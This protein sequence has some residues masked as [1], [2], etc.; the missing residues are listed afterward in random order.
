MIKYNYHAVYINLVGQ[1]TINKAYI[2]VLK[3]NIVILHIVTLASKDDHCDDVTTQDLAKSDGENN[4]F[5]VI[6]VAKLITCRKHPFTTK[7][8]RQTE[9]LTCMVNFNEYLWL[10]M[11]IIGNH[12]DDV[13]NLVIA[14]RKVGNIVFLL[15]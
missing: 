6:Y 2:M 7:S 13:I 10:S 9:N 5:Q 15:P 8:L 4:D 12:F 3:S 11:V 1:L 14:E